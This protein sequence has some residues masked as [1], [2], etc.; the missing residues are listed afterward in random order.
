[1][2][3]TKLALIALAMMFF[4]TGITEFIPVGL[5]PMFSQEFGVSLSEA[6]STVSLYAFGVAVGGVILTSLTAQINRKRILVGGVA[7]FLLGHI[8]M[9][10]AQSFAWLL[11]GRIMAAAAHGLFFAIA[12]S[13]A[14]SLV[15][16]T[17]SAGAIA[18]IFSGFT[19][20][21]AFAVPLGTYLSA[22]FSWRLPFWGVV[23]VS[24]FTLWLNWRYIPNDAGHIGN[25]GSAGEAG[26][27]EDTGTAGRVG[28]ASIADHGG[29]TPSWRDQWKLVTTPQI[30]LSLVI[31]VLGY[32]G[33]FATFTY[34]SPILQDIT[35]ISASTVS[36]VL[37]MYGVMIAI[38]NYLGG[39]FGNNDPLKALLYTFIVQGL[40]L[41]AFYFTAGSAVPAII[42]VAGMGL[43]AFMSVPMLQ[44]NIMLL[45][46]RYVPNAV[47]L[48][49][50]LN[51]AGFSGG[52]MLGAILGGFVIDWA[53]L[54]YTALAAAFMVGLSVVLTFG[55]VV[56]EAK[57][58]RNSHTGDAVELSDDSLVFDKQ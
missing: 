16:P 11:A 10:M 21:T 45:A 22:F 17:K 53:G 40:I 24:I 58:R 41:L 5:L 37:I 44:A 57:A 25:V 47:D 50:S 35:K 46:K 27:A 6:G 28:N 34:L 33:T 54:E 32:G 29:S 56:S 30:V 31:T 7:L 8:V 4:G 12:S 3:K 20:A 43:L 14:V 39:R 36:L 51:I 18:F 1:M 23:A 15:P 55:F 2:D 19:I 38:G 9:A 48:A 52:I 42:T 49:S 26:N 13:V